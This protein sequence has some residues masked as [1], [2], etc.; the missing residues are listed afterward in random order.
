VRVLK[1]RT[2]YL[3]RRRYRAALGQASGDAA[4]ALL[5]RIRPWTETT[6][7]G[8]FAE[9]GDLDPRDRHYLHLRAASEPGFCAHSGCQPGDGCFL[10]KARQQAAAADLLIVNHALLSIHLFGDRE[11]LPAADALIVDEAHGFVR[12]ALDHLTVSVGPG[13]V[14]SLLES[15]PGGGGFLPDAVRTGEGSTRLAALHR[16]AGRLEGAGREF[17][18]RKNGAP[19]EGDP[20]QRYRDAAEYDA[21]CPLSR[22]ALT[23]TVLGAVAD[24]EALEAWVERFATRDDDVVRGFL[25]EIRRF[26]EEGTLVARDLEALAEPDP[27]RGEVTWKE[28]GGGAFSLN[29]SPLEL[30]PALAPVLARGPSAVVFTSAT[31]AAGNDF[32]C[33]AR[34]VGF[35]VEGDLFTIAYPS[36][37]SFPD[38]AVVL[39]VRRSPDPRDAGWA[40]TTADTLDRLMRAPGR[41]TMALFTSY[42][43]LSRVHRIL[44][45]GPS[46]NGGGG[47]N[48]GGNAD[49][50]NPDHAGGGYDVLAQGG[51]GEVPRL[52][53][54]F[55]ASPRALLLGTSS[56]WEGIDLPGD[57][58]EIL[59]LTRLPF[60]VPTDPRFQARAERLEE[61][62]RNPFTDLYLPEAVLRFKQGFGRLIRRRSDRGIVAV[63]D[64]RLLNKGYGRRFAA[65]LPLPVTEATD[66][67][68]LAARAAAWWET[69]SMQSTRGDAS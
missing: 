68:D 59:V 17:F 43:D 25:G 38:Q 8:D 32:T 23:E 40:A 14:A 7:T 63:L 31:L 34:D 61:E 3:C 26:R 5:H 28:W 24:A 69:H 18:G 15:L 53:E 21:L 13:R 56:F 42:R 54:A 41:K 27:E 39:A 11:L 12:A 67:P 22:D 47:G 55:R 49:D 50:G 35:T 48:G 52:L 9:L 46:G 33:V 65:A 30:G 4:L 6:E 37:F 60:G 2:N 66:G 62:G 20:R 1:G 29:R 45:D 57:D 16:A 10:K 64:P 19:P 51:A 36:P 58:L 44:A